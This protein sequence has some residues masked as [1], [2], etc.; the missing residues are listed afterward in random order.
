MG[1]EG[2]CL[3]FCLNFGSL[4][5]PLDPILLAIITLWYFL[6]SGTIRKVE[7]AVSRENVALVRRE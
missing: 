6:A 2:H 1:I 4:F 5:G 7:V 3:E